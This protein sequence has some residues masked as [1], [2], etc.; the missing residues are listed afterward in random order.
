MTDAVKAEIPSIDELSLEQLVELKE[1]VE[2]KIGAE[3]AAEEAAL[4]KRQAELQKLTDR[5]NG[6]APP[7]PAPTR[8]KQASQTKTGQGDG[9]PEA[10]SDQAGAAGSGDASAPTEPAGAVEGAD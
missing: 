1:K 3:L 9:K 2:K 4:K 10:G 5:V 6:K 7:K 8:P